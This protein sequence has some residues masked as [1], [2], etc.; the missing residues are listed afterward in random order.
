MVSIFAGSKGYLDSLA[1]NQVRAFETELL[2]H[3]SDEFPEIMDEIKTKG[4]LSDEMTAKLSKLIENFKSR[5][6]AKAGAKK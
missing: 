3:V 2:K 4:E 6:V 5:F 1:N